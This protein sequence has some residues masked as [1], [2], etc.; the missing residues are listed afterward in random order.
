MTH[1]TQ[2]AN[3][4]TTP[5]ATDSETTAGTDTGDAF[6]SLELR[7]VEYP[8]GPTRCTMCPQGLTGIARMETWL[9]ADASAFV[10]LE[11]WR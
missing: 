3:P 4:A 5:A 7:C 1:E 11:G 8:D 6:E 10:D 9:T 2:G